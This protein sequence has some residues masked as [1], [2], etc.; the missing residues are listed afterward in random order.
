MKNLCSLS[1]KIKLVLILIFF[2]SS[3]LC[4][5]NEYIVFN[6]LFKG[7][8][9]SYTLNNSSISTISAVTGVGF[10]FT[11][12]A[13]TFATSLD[14]GSN[15]QGTITYSNNGV[16][17][18]ISGTISRLFK[19][20]NTKDGFYLYVNSTT[21]YLIIIPGR[22]SEFS[23]GN[24]Y[25]SDGSF[26]YNDVVTVKDNQ[27]AASNVRVDLPNATDVNENAND[28]NAYF[29]LSFS[30]S[31]TSS[32]GG[33][34]FTPSIVNGTTS[35][36]D[37]S[38]T[39]YYRKNS[40]DS[41][42][43]VPSGGISVLYSENTIYLKVAITSDNLPECAE[44]FNLET[45]AFTGSGA[46][47]INNNYGVFGSA[48]IIDDNDPLI[49]DGSSSTNWD[50][51][52]NWTPAL[53]PNSCYYIQIPASL[54]NYPD[55]TLSS[56]N[57]TIAGL[58][59]A[60]GAKLK[61]TSGT[62]SVKGPVVNDDNTNG[63]YSDGTL[64][65]NGTSAQ[66]ISGTGLFHNVKINNANGVSLSSG[67]TIITG[68]LTPTAGEITT[69]GRL[70]F[71]QNATDHGEVGQ[72]SGCPRTVFTGN[73]TIERY[74]PASNR[75]FRF[76]TPGVTTSTSIK[77]NWQENSNVTDP[78]AYPNTTVGS[79]NPILGYGTHITGSTTG[80]NGFDATLTGNPSMYTFNR[81]NQTWEAIGNTNTNTFSAGEAYRVLIRGSRSTDLT[82]NTPTIQATTIRTTGA[83]TTCDCSFST[84]PGT[85]VVG[86]L[87][88]TVGNYSFIGN[89]YWSVVDFNSL[90]ISGIEDNIYY[91]DP[92]LA[93]SNNRGVYVTYNKANN[94]K[95][96]PA[97]QVDQYIQPGQAF[98]VKTTNSTP[99]IAFGESKKSNG[100][101][102]NIF[103]INRDI[104]A[105]LEGSGPNVTNES[106]S[107]IEKMFIS[108]RMKGMPNNGI[109]DGCLLS[110]SDNFSIAY[111]KE[112]A[113]KMSNLD[114]NIALV[115]DEIKH[116][117]LGKKSDQI[118][119][120]DTTHISLWNLYEKTYTLEIDPRGM[121]NDQK[122]YFVNN[123]NNTSTLLKNN[124][125]FEYEFQPRAG[126][127]TINDFSIIVGNQKGIE[128]NVERLLI[129][130]NPAK[131][132]IQ[133]ILPNHEIAN[134]AKIF[135][136]NG[137]LIITTPIKQAENKLRTSNLPKGNYLLE[138][139]TA[140]RSFT[141]MFNK[142]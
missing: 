79:N 137:K 6:K 120:N 11:S 126:E 13:S 49:W 136:T 127:K 55:F 62:L 116:A 64:E 26:S 4:I 119:S 77:Q 142:L 83:L 108:L 7:S 9:S 138:I 51:A 27:Y 87:S 17:T 42:S 20:G 98:F 54:S 8:G 81:S 97:S 73:V 131:D 2:L 80:L 140:N 82:S 25:N 65:L 94:S 109:S 47:Q 99:S 34:S 84:Q 37:L 91:W 14:G 104:K 72:I 61:L 102:K 133:F 110:Y 44:N 78:N 66:T 35:S 89:P 117:I 30:A 139:K 43:T 67:S 103:E 101:K 50:L 141:S 3:N 122:I 32:N 112:D 130:P 71:R 118:L 70:V 18:S 75:S 58:N 48:N 41:W 132:E 24:S 36:S 19:T 53:S 125:L 121:A 93:G 5:G 107:A 115:N 23:A 31:R 105:P 134:W 135:D 38:S 111:G 88:S 10:K 76:L 92:T 69:N 22:E 56:T 90:T 114:E 123:K 106:S 39:I 100:N 85:G 12:Q 45:G 124:Q 95:T 29:T 60:S 40:S 129:Y 21:A 68:I 86:L 63:V 15:V 52:D 128:K 59:I 74:I 96:I 1:S 33:V 57:T 46:S 16:V 113:S 28:L